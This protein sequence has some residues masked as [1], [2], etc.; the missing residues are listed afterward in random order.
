MALISSHIQTSAIHCPKVLQKVTFIA[1]HRNLVQRMD[2]DLNLCLIYIK[3]FAK[4]AVVVLVLQ[5]V[6]N[7]LQDILFW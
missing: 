3:H 6:G 1:S 4:G 7:Q 2:Y 5:E